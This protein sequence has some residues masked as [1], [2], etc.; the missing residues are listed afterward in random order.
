MKDLKRNLI[1]WGKTFEQLTLAV[2]AGVLVYALMELLMNGTASLKTELLGYVWLFT[3]V[4]I[5][6]FG[7]TAVYSYFPLTVSL[8]SS[9]KTSF[10]VMQV[11]HHLCAIQYL[12]FGGVCY[13]FLDREMLTVLA[14]CLPT[15]FGVL[16][17]LLAITNLTCMISLKFG[18]AI[19]IIAYVVLVLLIIGTFVVIMVSGDTENGAMPEEVIDVIHKPHL[20][21]IGIMADIVSIGCYYPVMK[22]VDL[23]F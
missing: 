7:N 23:K 22:K 13:F 16:L 21:W 20:L 15:I 19:G 1:Y 14:V 4:V 10:L 2:M 8:G 12:L 6:V 3:C 9:R 5:F 18:K 11:M 17:L